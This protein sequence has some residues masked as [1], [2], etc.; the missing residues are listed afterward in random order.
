M[1]THSTI[2]HFRKATLCAVFALLAGAATSVGAQQQLIVRV[3]TQNYDIEAKAVMIQITGHHTNTPG[4]V[5]LT[6]PSL[7][8]SGNV[9]KPGNG[10]GPILLLGYTYDV[11]AMRDSSCNIGGYIVGESTT[12][13][14]VKSTATR[15]FT[16][17][18]DANGNGKLTI[19]TP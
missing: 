12:G 8:R 4:C 17:F 5:Q 6:P 14:T 2:R 7:D 18:K 11:Y 9:R 10:S 15:L 19:T 13:Y 3:N 16:I 1:Y